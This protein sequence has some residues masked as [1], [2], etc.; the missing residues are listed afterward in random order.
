MGQAGWEGDTGFDEYEAY[1]CQDSITDALQML[2][3]T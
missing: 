1:G 2:R 3:E